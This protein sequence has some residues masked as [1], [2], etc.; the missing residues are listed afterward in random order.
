[1]QLAAPVTCNPGETQIS[2]LD[3]K[4]NVIGATCS[5]GGDTCPAGYLFDANAQACREKPFYKKWQYWAAV[6]G[7]V[8]ALGTGVVLY[9]RRR[10]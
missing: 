1:M 10:R 5:A 6:A 4:G 8:A 2:L 9:R 3:R 7:G